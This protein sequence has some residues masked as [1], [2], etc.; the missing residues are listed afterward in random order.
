MKNMI[1]ALL[2]ASMAMS[3]ASCDD[4]SPVLTQKDWN[5]TT[6]YFSSTDEKTFGTYYQPYVGYVGDPM[7]FYDPVAGD[8]KIMYLQDFRPNPED[9]YHPIWAVLLI[10][11]WVN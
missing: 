5:G 10:H 9:T 8:F 11:Q 6:N 3:F 7:P 4:E 2:L 1:Y